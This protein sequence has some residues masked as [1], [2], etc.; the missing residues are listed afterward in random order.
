M[1]SS[2]VMAVCQALVEEG[3]ATFRFNF[4]GV[5]NSEGPFTKGEKEH[6]D[7][8]AALD[9]LIHWARCQERTGR[10]SGLFFR[11]LHGPRRPHQI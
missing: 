3:F 1:E 5:G 2:L 8:H 10:V 4:R 9:L 6:E 11:R 7:V